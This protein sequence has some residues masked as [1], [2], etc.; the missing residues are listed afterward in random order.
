MGSD[1]D[2]I[3]ENMKSQFTQVYVAVIVIFLVGV[4]FGQTGQEQGKQAPPMS[5]MGVPRQIKLLSDMT[6]TWK[7]QMKYKIDQSQPAWSEAGGEA[8]YEYVLDSCGIIG[9][10]SMDLMGLPYKGMLI[11]SYSRALAKYQSYW[12]DNM[13]TAPIV[14]DGVRD[15]SGAVMFTGS[16]IYQGKTAYTRMT[17][18]MPDKKTL[19]ME[20]EDSYDGKTYHRSMEILHTKQ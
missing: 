20:F 14:D 8:K 11:I 17:Q 13:A 12:L 15:S 2:N 9:H 7:T 19:V 1:F 18:R 3:G 10:Y 16:E 6:G 5:E 4:V